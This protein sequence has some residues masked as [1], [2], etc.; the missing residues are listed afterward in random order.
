MSARVLKQLLGTTV[1]VA[2]LALTPAASADGWTLQAGSA[3]RALVEQL[4]RWPL[5]L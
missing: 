3:A 5:S 4:A 1:A 2:A